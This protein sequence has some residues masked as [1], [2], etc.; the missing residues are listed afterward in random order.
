MVTFHA[1]SLDVPPSPLLSGMFIHCVIWG[2][3][4]AGGNVRMFTR[5]LLVT[6][7][8]QLYPRR[9]I[10]ESDIKQSIYLDNKVYV[11]TGSLCTYFIF[12]V[13]FLFVCS[14]V[15]VLQAYEYIQRMRADMRG[16]N[17]LGA[18]SW[19]Y[20]QP[21]QRS[22]PRQIFIITDGSIS[23]VAKVLELVRHNTCAGRYWGRKR[24][25]YTFNPKNEE[26]NVHKCKNDIKAMLCNLQ[27]LS[28][29][30]KR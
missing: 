5:S 4:K 11:C 9:V 13:P 20:Q 25:N 16:T 21:M 3:F 26:C 29:I 19:L 10:G 17:L 1:F 2:G 7:L 30:Y 8:I 18:L 6:P 14:Q 24:A 28:R 22:Y 27:R 23:N 12:P 15:T